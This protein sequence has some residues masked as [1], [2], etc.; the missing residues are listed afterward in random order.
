MQRVAEA[1]GRDP[2]EPVRSPEEAV[3]PLLGDRPAVHRVQPVESPEA[4][5]PEARSEATPPAV[6]PPAVLP[7]AVPESAVPSSRPH[8][9]GLGAPLTGLPPSVQRSSAPPPVERPAVRV[10]VGEPLPQVPS[11]PVEPSGVPVPGPVVPVPAAQASATP[12]PVVPAREPAPAPAPLPLVPLQRLV[13][14]DPPPYEAAP[15]GG[16]L[17][18]LVGERGL[19]LSSAPTP[20]H[21]TESVDAPHPQPQPTP[22]PVPV[23]WSA[24]SEQPARRQAVPLPAATSRT[25][26]RQVESRPAV[27]AVTFRTVQREAESRPAA[28]AALLPVRP[29]DR[30]EDP[31]SVAVAAGIAQRMP[32]GSVRFEPPRE[33]QPTQPPS[34]VPLQRTAGAPAPEAPPASATS[35]TPPVQPTPPPT[36]T[37]P[38]PPPAPPPESTD[39][40]VRRLIDPLSRLLRAELRLDRERAGRRLDDPRR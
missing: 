13:L 25:V 35:E 14:P 39:D 30:P 24:P 2:G 7:S 16:R 3:A 34:P 5:V 15:G 4:G 6:L 10:R 32:D 29:W 9:L 40:L 28:P 23:A 38:P 17:T 21:P 19:E 37:T 22:A 31:G 11:P 36:A 1:P 12:A 8:R 27:P 18:G 26:Q 20:G 33:P